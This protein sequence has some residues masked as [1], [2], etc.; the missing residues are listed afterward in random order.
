M[1]PIG[2]TLTLLILGVLVALRT[3]GQDL[4]SMSGL[5]GRALFGVF[6]AATLGFALPFVL[7]YAF[8]R[9]LAPEYL[10]D[11]DF[12]GRRPGRLRHG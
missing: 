11:A 3:R 2:A 9:D 6:I 10:K 1:I 4:G 5:A 8:R 7:R 12:A